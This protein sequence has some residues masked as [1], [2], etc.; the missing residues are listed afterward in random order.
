MDERRRGRGPWRMH[1]R[2]Q[3][4]L[5]CLYFTT[6][7]RYN[8]RADT[9]GRRARKKEAEKGREKELLFSPLILTW[10]PSVRLTVDQSIYLAWTLSRSPPPLPFT[11]SSPSGSAPNELIA[12]VAKEKTRESGTKWPLRNAVRP[13]VSSFLRSLAHS[14]AS[15]RQG[16]N[17]RD[18]VEGEERGE[19]IASW[20][21]NRGR[22]TA[23]SLFHWL[24]SINNPVARGA[25]WI[26]EHLPRNLYTVGAVVL[27]IYVS[28]ASY[29]CVLYI[30]YALSTSRARLAFFPRDRRWRLRLHAR[31][32]R[33]NVLLSILD[34]T[35]RA[36]QRY[37]R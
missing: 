7:V 14:V 25:R 33:F 11:S 19:E 2:E 1:H 17:G 37:L 12:R 28:R 15:F 13:S 3:I 32:L 35:E 9:H 4:P 21:L 26:A 18:R 10:L 23:I 36:S 20:K 29:A 24:T 30:Y 5:P 31:P 27:C 6:V 22:R 34:R 8:T 16:C